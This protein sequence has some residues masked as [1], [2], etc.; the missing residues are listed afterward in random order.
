MEIT[1]LL[2]VSQKNNASDLHISVGNPPLL[3]VNGDMIPLKMSA[4]GPDENA[5]DALQHHDRTAT[6]GI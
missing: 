4:L 6:H 2:L 5:P 3:R 1:E